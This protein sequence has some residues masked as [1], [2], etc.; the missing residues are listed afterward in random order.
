MG[1]QQLSE[2]NT[3][4]V[5]SDTH[6][7]PRMIEDL[8]PY[9]PSKCLE[10]YDAFVSEVL[11][12]RDWWTGAGVPDGMSA[13]HYDSAARA[14]ILDGDRIAAEV[15]FQ[16]SFNGELIPF[17]PSFL[18]SDNPSNL[19]LAPVG[20]HIYNQWL[21]DFCAALPGRRVGL[22][23][24]PLWDI[25]AA[26]REVEWAAEAG[27]KGINFPGMRES[28]VPYDDPSY[29]PLWA[30]CAAC[31]MP[32]TTHSGAS[33]P[34]SMNN[35]SILMLEVGGALNRR[36]IHRMIFSGAFDRHPSLKL[37][38]T[39]QPG[40]WPVAL[41]E[42]MNSAYRATVRHNSN[43]DTGALTR[44]ATKGN[45]LSEPEH[46][47]GYAVNMKRQEPLTRLP[48]EYFGT[49]VFIGASFMAHFEAELAIEHQFSN[50]MMW[51]S[52]YP[53]PEGCRNMNDNDYETSQLLR[54]MRM[55]FEGLPEAEI[56]AMTGLNAI[57]CYGLDGE[58]LAKVAESLDAP[59][60]AELAQ[61]PVGTL[62]GADGTGGHAFRTEQW[63]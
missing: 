62:H 48:S 20:Q 4:I 15:L 47:K 27:L 12:V 42:E 11:P 34:S 53:H 3:V 31:D 52:D 46:W 2:A 38:M 55:S 29:E 40:P 8:R 39:E 49:N 10:A 41:F 51:G 9:C 16:F 33:S 57:R 44:N 50:S 7:G 13:G 56:R 24:I 25:D 6:I 43:P 1:D 63:G 22:A 5:T 26:V 21:A 17:V 59:T 45:T 14:A 61:Q 54:S 23:H 60:P 32:L 18:H 36:A 30:A 58:Q 37:V 35:Q 28:L 19:E